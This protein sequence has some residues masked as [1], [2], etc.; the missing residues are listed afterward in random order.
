MQLEVAHRIVPA[1]LLVGA[2]M[3]A[4]AQTRPAGDSL[5]VPLH[6]LGSEVEDRWRLDQLWGRSSSAGFLLRSASSM[7]TS[8]SGSGFRSGFLL[9]Q[10]RV[11]HNSAVP[12]P[13][14]DGSLWAGRGTGGVIMAGYRAEWRGV[15]LVLAP[16]FVYASN[17]HIAAIDSETYYFPPIPPHR[18][19]FASRWHVEPNSIDTPWRFG[20]EPIQQLHPGQSSLALRARGAQLGIS[21][22]NNWWGPGI[23]NAILLSSNA[24]GFPHV[25][26]R[27]AHPVRTRVGAF[28]ARWLMGALAESRFFDTLSTNDL[29][30]FSAAAVTW[31]PLWEPD[32]TFGVARA[33]Y[34]PMDR[35]TDLTGR[36]F[37]VFAV[38][39]RPSAGA[40]SEEPDRAA[41]QLVS[42]FWRWLFPRSGFEFYGEW[43]RTELPASLSDFLVAPNHTQGYTLGMQW[44]GTGPRGTDL[45]RVQGEITS[46]QQ[47]S[48]DPARAGAP[49]YTSRTI[50]Q[51]YTNR[52]QVLG[53]AIGQGSSSQWLAVD[54]VSP[55]WRAGAFAARIRWDDD[56]HYSIPW[57]EGN[58]W[59]EHD[60]SLL[61]GVRGAWNTGLATISADL[62]AGQRLNAFHQNKSGCPNGPFRVDVRNT[63]LSIA[64]TP[65]IGNN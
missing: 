47:S 61:P 50:P 35:W 55:R 59:C 18:S 10:T 25:F 42:L 41:D 28:E 5:V 40:S 38:T 12:Y 36:V 34:S 60:V 11:S 15:M 64:I 49:F 58:G 6:T 63:T 14:N 30:S 26:V 44:A 3:V 21:T 22:E 8:L 19:P 27:T 4:Q 2:S 46:L 33:V 48:G 1:V 45:F 13:T 24:P 62:T 54:Y 57:P 23:R 29:R 7:T 17:Q 9:P 16:E 65:A 31:Q 37:D 39:D 43:A 32:L 53:A 51:G 56:T 20:D 52:G